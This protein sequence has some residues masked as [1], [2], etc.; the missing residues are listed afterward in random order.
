VFN[1]KLKKRISDIEERL[2]KL[3]NNNQIIRPKKYAIPQIEESHKKLT[4]EERSSQRYK[5]IK[6]TS[7]LHE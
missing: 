7:E 1:R 2:N 4:E 6:W 3:E 5:I